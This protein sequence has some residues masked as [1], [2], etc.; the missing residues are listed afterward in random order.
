VFV[1]SLH[2][3]PSVLVQALRD[4]TDIEL[5]RVAEALF[6]AK[7]VMST[8]PHAGSLFYDPAWD[9]LL[10][11]YLAHHAKKCVSVKGASLATNAPQTT[12]LRQV[13]LLESLALIE[14]Q[15]DPH[16]RRRHFVVLTRDGVLLIEQVLDAY[17][18]QFSRL[19][20][21]TGLAANP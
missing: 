2:A 19:L 9:I 4:V 12:A 17:G 21:D 13:W 5:V 18:L 1:V 10:D 14:R 16:D 20:E 8:L 3:K 6:R 7:R 11:L 15:V